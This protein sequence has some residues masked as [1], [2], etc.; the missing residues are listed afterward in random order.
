M[1]VLKLQTIQPKRATS[2][3]IAVRSVT[4]SYSECCQ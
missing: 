2:N 3:L 4:S 1:S